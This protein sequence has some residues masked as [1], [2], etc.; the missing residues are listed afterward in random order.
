MNGDKPVG[1]Q[2]FENFC[3]KGSKTVLLK[4]VKIVVIINV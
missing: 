4:A 2:C 3:P 1:L